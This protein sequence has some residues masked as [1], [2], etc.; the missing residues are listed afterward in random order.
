[1]QLICTKLLE[2]LGA[3][4]HPPSSICRWPKLRKILRYNFHPR[5]LSAAVPDSKNYKAGGKN[6]VQKMHAKNV[7]E[8]DTRCQFHQHLMSIFLYERV[9]CSFSLF[10]YVIFWLKNN[11]TKAACKIL[12]KSTLVSNF[13]K[14]LKAA[15]LYERVL[16]SFA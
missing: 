7:D 5:Y 2:P 10:G 16:H 1:M 12:V 8:I 3:S 15:F 4:P 13:T 6:F 9:L 11:I 14:I